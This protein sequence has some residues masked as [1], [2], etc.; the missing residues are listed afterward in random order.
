MPLY[1]RSIG[2]KQKS[3]QALPDIKEPCHNKNIITGASL[4]AQWLRIRLPMQGTRVRALV[5]EDPTCHRAT[6]PVR[7]DY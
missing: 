1:N 7:H 4:V 2:K 3:D 6:K 5:R